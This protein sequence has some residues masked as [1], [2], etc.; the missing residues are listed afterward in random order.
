ML[1]SW[2]FI[3]LLS[4]TPLA[5]SGSTQHGHLP[6]RGSPLNFL[7]KWKTAINEK[8]HQ[9]S[10]SKMSYVKDRPRLLTGLSR[11]FLDV[12]VVT[13]SFVSITQWPLQ[14]SLIKKA[15]TNG[16]VQTENRSISNRVPGPSL[17]Y[18]IA[19]RL[20]SV[21]SFFERNNKIALKMNPQNGRNISF[22]GNKLLIGRTCS[23]RTILEIGR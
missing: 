18:R 10:S 13:H 20:V 9:S 14:K 19:K 21:L 7:R 5:T 23:A 11:R 6:Q 1:H 16:K 15:K 12:P 17:S 8:N 4:G 22:N 2:R 3:P